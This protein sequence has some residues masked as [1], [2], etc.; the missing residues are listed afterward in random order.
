MILFINMVARKAGRAIK[1]EGGSHLDHDIRAFVIVRHGRYFL[2]WLMQL[3][4]GE[5]ER[6]ADAKRNAQILTKKLIIHH[7]PPSQIRR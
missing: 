5:E 1:S 4:I 7:H 3:T 6:W 2:L